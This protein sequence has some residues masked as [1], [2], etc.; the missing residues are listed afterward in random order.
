MGGSGRL[1]GN[2]DDS[3]KFPELPCGEKFIEVARAAA[4]KRTSLTF[5]TKFFSYFF[6]LI[7][8]VIFFSFLSENVLH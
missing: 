3:N 5:G 4:N 1:A 8:H 2:S 6:F 7:T